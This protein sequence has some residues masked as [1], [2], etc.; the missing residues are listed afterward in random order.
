[1]ESFVYHSEDFRAHLAD[2]P[3]VRGEVTFL[4][5]IAEPGMTVLDIG[6]NR[7]V[8][9]VALARAVGPTGR[10]LAF[11]PIPDHFEVL[12]ES[13]RRNDVDNVKAF[14]MA[15]CEER[16]E[17]LLYLNGS[18][19][20]IAADS[21]HDPVEVPCHSVDDLVREHGLRH[22]DIIS[23]DCEGSELFA[24]Q[25]ARKT[26]KHFSPQIFCE[27]HHSALKAIG[28]S[29]DDL[30]DF[31]ETMDYS[32]RPL[33]IEDLDADPPVDECSHIY[34]VRLPSNQ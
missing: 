20:G 22:V 4:G 33:M 3:H 32:V 16:R 27:M 14:R 1:M 29:P 13:L 5:R 26:L 21:S 11:E 31:L 19:T 18:G 15:A 12:Q 28:H 9:T 8:T 23:S 10:V 7:G 17:A 2:S 24:L 25:G 30:V 34:A 6:A